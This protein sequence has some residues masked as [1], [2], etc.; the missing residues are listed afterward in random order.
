M[1]IEGNN[2]INILIEKYEKILAHLDRES[3]AD[4]KL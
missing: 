2:Q 4:H 3:K 1:R